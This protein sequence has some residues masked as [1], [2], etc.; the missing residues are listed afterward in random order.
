MVIPYN[1]TNSV[2]DTGPL[3]GFESAMLAHYS[4]QE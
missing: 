4:N 2:A 1:T 3:T